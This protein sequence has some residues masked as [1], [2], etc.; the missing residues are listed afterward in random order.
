MAPRGWGCEGCC[1]QRALRRALACA[2]GMDSAAAAAADSWTDDLGDLDDMEELMALDVP[3]P[4]PPPPPPPKPEPEPPPSDELLDDLA[5]LEGLDILEPQPQPGP[6]VPEPEPEAPDEY[7]SVL[8]GMRANRQALLDE[9]TAHRTTFDER[10]KTKKS[11][12]A[13]RQARQALLG[14]Q[15]AAAAEPAAAPV[16]AP[17]PAPAPAPS[18]PAAGG[19]P[20]FNMLAS[21]PFFAGKRKLSFAAG[22]TMGEMHAQLAKKAGGAAGL[23]IRVCITAEQHGAT[24]I[25]DARDL[26]STS[27]VRVVEA[28]YCPFLRSVFTAVA[29]AA[30][31]GQTLT[32]A[33]MQAAAQQL[34]AP[35][36]PQG[37][38]AQLAAR[39]GSEAVTL[40]Y[41]IRFWSGRSSP[42]ASEFERRVV[43]GM[44]SGGAAW[45]LM[46]PTGSPESARVLHVEG[47]DFFE[48]CVKVWTASHCRLPILP[49]YF[50]SH[51]LKYLSK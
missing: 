13:E 31:P 49:F 32:P 34:L 40:E 33:Q 39:I 5:A 10:R 51:L 47:E 44:G 6:L 14:A 2:T 25:T 17:A 27:W 50:L 15:S 16:P 7:N 4:L 29:G 38:D 35:D 12:K 30:S 42:K 43:A 36:R 41:F 37:L 26:P 46:G 22:S 21:S 48:G 28:R 23:P 9:H 11:K 18:P 24:E 1:G 19:G 45:L 20:P 3:G 8:S